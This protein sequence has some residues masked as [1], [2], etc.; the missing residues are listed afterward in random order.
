MT[1]RI[2]VAGASGRMG[3]MLIEAIKAADDCELA[4]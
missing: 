3:Q 4:G 2:T 1:H